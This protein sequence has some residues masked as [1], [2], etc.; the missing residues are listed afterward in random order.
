MPVELKVPEVGESIT[1]VQIGQWRKQVGQAAGKDESLVEIESDKATV[2][3]PAPIAG[4]LTQI[5]KQP[6][7][8]AQVGEVI[9]YMAAAT[10]APATRADTRIDASPELKAKSVARVE[11]EGKQSPPAPPSSERVVLEHAGKAKDVTASEGG[12]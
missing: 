5:L 10:E 3:L 9:G 6:G 4:T 8:K 1:D 7:E 2:D 11:P 12:R